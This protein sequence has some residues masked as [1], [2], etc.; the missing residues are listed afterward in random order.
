M[1]RDF[2]TKLLRLANEIGCFSGKQDHFEGSFDIKLVIVSTLLK[3]DGHH[4][5][6]MLDL[7]DAVITFTPF[8]SLNITTKLRSVSLKGPDSQQSILQRSLQSHHGER[9]LFKCT[10]GSKLN[11]IEISFTHLRFT[12]PSPEALRQ[13]RMLSK[14]IYSIPMI[15]ASA[16]PPFRCAVSVIKCYVSFDLGSD[17][18]LRLNV[19][20][21]ACEGLIHNDLEFTGNVTNI[22]L[23]LDFKR[24]SFKFATM[25]STTVDTVKRSTTVCCSAVAIEAIENFETLCQTI[26]KCHDMLIPLFEKTTSRNEVGDQ[27]SRAELFSA[28][29]GRQQESTLRSAEDLGF[30]YFLSADV[31][32]P[33][34]AATY[35]GT[36]LI[37]SEFPTLIKFIKKIRGWY[38]FLFG[39][40]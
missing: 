32:D 24:R 18:A 16:H 37:R 17:Y 35:S 38:D 28:A 25:R 15:N 19:A 10:Y 27:S 26:S 20:S 5:G 39:C 31:Y 14:A 7:L 40:D 2:F 13:L 22:D 8:E 3:S 36:L 23:W 33:M 12:L 9:S 1:E 34:Q 4:I 30:F 21:A 29:Q 11:Q 6:L